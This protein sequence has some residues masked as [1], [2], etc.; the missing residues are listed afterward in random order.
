MGHLVK[1]QRAAFILRKN[2]SSDNLLQVE[3]DI[4]DIRLLHEMLKK[5]H[6]DDDYDYLI[7]EPILMANSLF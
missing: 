2:G 5:V 6:N 7:I 1:T 4:Y 3:G